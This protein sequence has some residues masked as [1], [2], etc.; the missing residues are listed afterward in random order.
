M[1][2]VTRRLRRKF[3][4]NDKKLENGSEKFHNLCSSPYFSETIELDGRDKGV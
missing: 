1:M 4:G 2:F 3:M